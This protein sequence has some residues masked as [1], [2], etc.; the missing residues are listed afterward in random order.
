MSD[1]A[2]V[3]RRDHAERDRRTDVA[4]QVFGKSEAV[5]SLMEAVR[6]IRGEGGEPNLARFS[7]L[8]RAVDNAVLRK[9][10][11]KFALWT[12]RV[13]LEE[14]YGWECLYDQ[15]KKEEEYK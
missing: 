9:K 4:Q 6:S 5:D 8:K 13:D 15:Q 11:I 10:P 1:T 2:L 3:D 14:Y 12:L 7:E